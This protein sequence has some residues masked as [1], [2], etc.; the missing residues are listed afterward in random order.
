MTAVGQ[1]GIKTKNVAVGLPSGKTFTTVVDIPTMSEAELKATMKYQID[2]YV[3][4]GTDEAK[5]DW[6]LLGS[7]LRAQNQEEVLITSVSKEYSEERLELVESLG[8]NV[9]AEEPD[10][11]AMVRA[12]VPANSANTALML[13]DMG[14]LSADIAIT[15]GD[16][17]RLIRT[18]PTQ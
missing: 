14:E 9:I 4:M 5:V 18:I 1:S 12:L 2:Q 3:P 11:L 7:S 16:T 6:A 8:L 17:P 13:V 10:P 15:Y